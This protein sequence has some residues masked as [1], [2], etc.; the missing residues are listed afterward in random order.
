MAFQCIIK[1]SQ[2]SGCVHS[3]AA[4]GVPDSMCVRCHS[5]LASHMRV[6]GTDMYG[7]LTS[8]FPSHA[9]EGG[10]GN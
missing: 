7:P 4:L 8:P 2:T 3:E 5:G 1:A 9:M 6:S 10:P